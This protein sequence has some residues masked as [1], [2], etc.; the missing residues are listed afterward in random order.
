MEIEPRVKLDGFIARLSDLQHNLE[1]EER[2]AKMITSFDHS[3]FSRIAREMSQHHL[4]LKY[5]K[6]FQILFEETKDFLQ[7]ISVVKNN[8]PSEGNSA[9]F[10]KKL[11]T[12][13]KYSKLNTKIK[14]M[15]IILTQIKEEYL[16]LNSQISK[17]SREQRA[18]EKN[19][20]DKLLTK[21]E[22]IF[23]NFIKA[24][25]EDVAL[26]WW[27]THIP[28]DIRKKA[29]H[30]KIRDKNFVNQYTK[31]PHIIDYVDFI[32]Y[33]TIITSETNWNIFEKVFEDK[34]AVLV[35]F[36]ELKPIR[37]AIRHSR[38]VNFNQMQ[39]LQLYSNDLI[40]LIQKSS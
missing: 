40:D 2:K 33:A 24:K 22:Q 8:L 14:H 38:N 37:N 5:T 26:D 20:Q 15:I 13:E 11:V 29:E 25:L 35:K 31:K 4:L 27:I 10:L 32:D 39:R 34:C 17:Y 18:K 19:K 28:A 12:I 23:R 16:I 30:A 9:V 1:Y 3:E 21:L 7:T 36:N 6:P